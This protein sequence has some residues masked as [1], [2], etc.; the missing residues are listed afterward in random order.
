MTT[1]DPQECKHYCVG[2]C[3]MTDISRPCIFV[4]TL[5]KILP[6]NC[7]DFTPKTDKK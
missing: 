4:C 2:L 7:P 1:Q 5:A 3:I 6:L